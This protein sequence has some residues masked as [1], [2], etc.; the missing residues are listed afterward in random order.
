M[1]LLWIIEHGQLDRKYCTKV[2]YPKI[3]LFEGYTTEKWHIKRNPNLVL[4]LSSV[5][6]PI[7]SLVLH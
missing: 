2:K 1:G 3:N 6:F 7:Q 4:Y 5:M